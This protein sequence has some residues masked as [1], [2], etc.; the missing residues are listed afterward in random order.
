MSPGAHAAAVALACSTA[1]MSAAALPVSSRAAP[2]LVRIWT[3]THGVK[4][5]AR[6][7]KVAAGKAYLRR[8]NGKVVA[9]PVSRLS[10][11]D[12]IWA[13]VKERGERVEDAKIGKTGKD[14]TAQAVRGP[15]GRP[16][17]YGFRFDGSCVYRG[18]RPVT[19]WSETSNI[20]W[21]TE[22]PWWGHGQGCLAKGRIF[23]MC[24]PLGSIAG[25]QLLCISAHTGDIVWRRDVHMFDLFPENEV[26]ADRADWLEDRRVER[27]IHQSARQLAKLRPYLLAAGNPT[28]AIAS[29]RERAVKLRERGKKQKQVV[30][31]P[32]AG[33]WMYG[34]LAARLEAIAATLENDTPKTVAKRTAEFSRWKIEADRLHIPYGYTVTRGEGILT[35]LA[36]P[37]A[38]EFST[39]YMTPS[40]QR[41]KPQQDFRAHM[42]RYYGLY[43]NDWA[44]SGAFSGRT[45]FGSI[46]TAFPTPVTDGE[47]VYVWT[48]NNVA[49]CYDTDRHCKWLRWFGPLPRRCGMSFMSSPILVDN[50]LILF[51]CAARMGVAMR[52]LDAA[53]GRTLWERGAVPEIVAGKPAV[54]EHHGT[55]VAVMLGT[56]PA[57]FAPDATVTR[58][59]DGKL[60]GWI[61][62]ETGAWISGWCSPAARTPAAK[63]GTAVVYFANGGS[64]GGGS[65]VP[66]GKPA[67]GSV[68]AVKLTFVDEK[69]KGERLWVCKT[70]ISKGSQIT[71]HDGL[72]YADTLVIDPANGSVLRKLPVWDYVRIKRERVR[73]SYAEGSAHLLPVAGGRLYHLNREGVCMVFETG[74]TNAFVAAN[75]LG[76]PE[77]VFD[78][79]GRPGHQFCY[80]ASPWFSGNRIFLRSPFHLYCVGNPAEP[81][82]L[83]PGQDM[84]PPPA[85]PLPIP[86]SLEGASVEELVKFIETG[87]SGTVMAATREIRRRLRLPASP[88]TRH[89]T[90]DTLLPALLPALTRHH[91]EQLRDVARTL[92]ALGPV[93]AKPA[94]PVLQG[95]LTDENP[96]SRIH[97]MEALA[98][99]APAA[100]AEAVPVLLQGLSDT[101]EPRSI[102]VP[103]AQAFRPPSVRDWAV[104]GLAAAGKHATNAIP[105]LLTMAGKLEDWEWYWDGGTGTRLYRRLVSALAAT[106][107][108]NVL[109]DHVETKPSDGELAASLMAIAKIRPVSRRSVGLALRTR[110]RNV[111]KIRGKILD[112][113]GTGAAAGLVE[114]LKSRNYGVPQTAGDYLVRIGEPALPELAMHGNDKTIA[115]RVKII[116]ARIKVQ[117]KGP[118]GIP[119]LA[120][121][122]KDPRPETRRWAIDTIKGYGV[123]A[124][125]RLRS[126]VNDNTMRAQAI[127]I[128]DHIAGAGKLA[129]P[130]LLDLIR[131]STNL[132][133]LTIAD[134]LTRRGD[135]MMH[136]LEPYMGDPHVG[137][138]A[139]EVVQR[140]KLSNN[141]GPEAIP[142]LIAYLR[143]PSAEAQRW[144]AGQL[145]IRGKASIP[146]LVKHE[147]DP[148]I[149]KTVKELI[150]AIDPTRK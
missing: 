140:I 35:D 42:S 28:N 53:T 6:L 84:L 141:R 118:A 142:A 89:P 130:G 129:V 49:A 9:I 147:N 107:A 90:A 7:E 2:P 64:G 102:R 73:R 119:E 82:S 100:P 69:V 144:A 16:V 148:A 94:V 14:A 66:A 8:T 71:Y 15:P 19:H 57:L 131:A 85:G 104:I 46:G 136:L 149:G 114:A 98:T 115:A 52:A 96:I 110:G 32:R 60:L 75:A 34:A 117:A 27:R 72:L 44:H 74:R 108:A 4:L 55:P 139:T 113:M 54:G 38:L 112:A 146:E 105:T 13:R 101:T 58:V 29:Y 143:H 41:T 61:G 67:A 111:W 137:T 150:R 128:I 91:M 31:G 70:D 10:V 78:D 1:V 80:G 76:M 36:Q 21:R 11:V 59:S 103:K 120:K 63:D 123:A 62:E 127:E 43:Y 22:L 121:Y 99:L 135:P 48:G 83:T 106:G 12:R 86:V 145:R 40:F 126:V 68:L 30:G 125:P 23:I 134:A 65:A 93:A 47:L 79:R 51:D 138:V 26:S 122:L 88:D 116:T 95:M 45:G 56:T 124:L 37:R 24:E 77:H 50:K 33:A 5:L 3:S 39:S 25:V 133:K 87:R 109:C 81:T 17:A 92:V 18:C 132:A 20:V 97:A